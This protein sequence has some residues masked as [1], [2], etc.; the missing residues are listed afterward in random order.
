MAVLSYKCSKNKPTTT[1][2]D[3]F[4]PRSPL[5]FF[6]NGKLDGDLEAQLGV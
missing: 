6:A 4:V 1:A 3:S 5:S 2:F